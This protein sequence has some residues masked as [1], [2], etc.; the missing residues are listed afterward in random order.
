M[1]IVKNVLIFL[2]DENLTEYLESQ[3]FYITHKDHLK[4]QHSLSSCRKQIKF[5]VYGCF[6]G[7]NIK[8]VSGKEPET[9]C[10]M[11]PLASSSSLEHLASFVAPVLLVFQSAA[12]YDLLYPGCFYQLV[13]PVG[14]CSGSVSDQRLKQVLS[15]T[16]IRKQI[17]VNDH[18]EILDVE[19]TKQKGQVSLIF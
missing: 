13:G 5:H 12:Y 1:V 2:A 6:I 15:K 7:P 14:S 10:G 19:L 4:H 18:M 9:C 16:G 17:Y 11:T 3:L 8:L